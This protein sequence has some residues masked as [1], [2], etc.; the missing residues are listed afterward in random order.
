MVLWKLGVSETVSLTR[1]RLA[2]QASIGSHCRYHAKLSTAQAFSRRSIGM[3]GDEIVGIGTM[4]L[5]AQIYPD[6][7]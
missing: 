6:L 3:C 5:F 4:R 2:P 7:E 1:E